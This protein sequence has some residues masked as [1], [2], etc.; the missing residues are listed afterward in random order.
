M[1]MIKMI[2]TNDK[3]IRKL[4]LLTIVTTVILVGILSGCTGTEDSNEIQTLIVEGSTTVFPIAN[5]T[6]T[7]INTEIK[8][9]RDRGC[10]SIQ[11]KLLFIIFC[12]P[13]PY[14]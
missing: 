1:R 9:I 8:M 12:Y 10:C 11:P 7:R 6:A 14:S 4:M 3:K 13:F 5:A 2:N